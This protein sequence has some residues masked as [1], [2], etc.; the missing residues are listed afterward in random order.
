M[1][2]PDEG[3]FR[4]TAELLGLEPAECV[5]VDDLP[6][7]VRG[8]V[9]AGMVGVQH[10]DYASTLAELEALFGIPLHPSP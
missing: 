4:Y 8:A 6:H 2:K 3:I 5:M 10:T 1:R 9:A 7:N